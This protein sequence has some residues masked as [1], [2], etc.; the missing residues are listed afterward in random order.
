MKREYDRQSDAEVGPTPVFRAPVFQQHH[1]YP[2]I[3]A[4]LHHEVNLQCFSFGAVRKL[5]QASRPFPVFW[6]CPCYD[7]PLHP[8]DN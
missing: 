6:Q 2:G 5:G 4:W 3:D 7:A 1:A 8:L